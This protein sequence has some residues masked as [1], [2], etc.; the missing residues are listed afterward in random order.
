MSPT[1]PPADK[2][3]MRD[4]LIALKGKHG[5][6]TGA[7]RAFPARSEEQ[8]RRDCDCGLQALIDRLERHERWAR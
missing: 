3:L 1:P 4:L 5:R 2:H 8:I 6:H 7:C